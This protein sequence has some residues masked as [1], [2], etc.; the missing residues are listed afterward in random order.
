MCTCINE[1]AKKQVTR[2]MCFVRL[3]YV[4]H[5]WSRRLTLDWMLMKRLRVY[6][7]GRNSGMIMNAS[8]VSKHFS[9]VPNYQQ[10]DLLNL[11]RINAADKY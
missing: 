1:H 7:R 3:R 10:Y 8:R 6:M 2:K 5:M 11:P 9:D 4:T